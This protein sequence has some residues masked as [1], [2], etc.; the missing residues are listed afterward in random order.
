MLTPKDSHCLHLRSYPSILILH[1]CMYK[2]V[3]KELWYLQ[4]KFITNSVL[5]F[6]FYLIKR[7][8]SEFRVLCFLF[9]FNA[10]RL[11]LFESD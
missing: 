9:H 5:C 3:K 1:K 7:N 11:S 10:M 6:A 2:H 8:F 4:N